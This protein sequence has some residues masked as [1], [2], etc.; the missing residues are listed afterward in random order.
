MPMTH[1]QLAK[2][3]ADVSLLRGE[4]T[5]RSGRKSNYYL[6]KYRFETQPD[7][8]AELGRLFATK[9]G[10]DVRRIAGPELGAVALAAAASI[11]S[12][13]PF[14]LVRNKKKDYGSAKAIEGVLEK[15]DRVVIVED[16]MTTGG[17]VLEAAKSLEA[18]GATI[19]KIIGVIDRLEG[20]RANIEQAGYVFE[21]LFTTEDLGIKKE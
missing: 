17:Q 15:G 16:I 8:L 13:K 6:D 3:I 7:V 10:P 9:I 1:A 20:A 14:V 19:V 12:G 21:S 18:E 4:F 5:L 11:S 2:R